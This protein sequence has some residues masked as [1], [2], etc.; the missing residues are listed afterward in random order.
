MKEIMI[1]LKPKFQK[2]IFQR[3]V[4]KYGGSVKASEFVDIPATSIRGYKNIYF[5]SV[6]KIL[7]NQLIKLKLVRNSEIERNSLFS[8]NKLDL[9]KKNLDKGREKRKQNLIILKKNIP[10][11]KELINE[12]QI[13]VTKWFKEYL[14]LL[15][16]G[17][18]KASFE[19]IGEDIKINYSNFNKKIYK[20]FEVKIPQK[21]LIDKDFV[22]FFGL[23]C[24]DRAGGKRFG[25]C[26][27]NKE[28]LNYTEIFLKKY[29]QKIEKILYISKGLKEP[30]LEY[31]KRFIINKETKG[32]C[33]SVHSPNGILASFFRYLLENLEE[34]LKSLKDKEVFFAGLFDAEG[35]VSLYNGSF[36]WACKNLPQVKIY[37]KILKELGFK[38][39]YDGAC[40]VSY[41]KKFF[42]N[43]I[44]PYIKHGNKINKTLLL[45]GEGGILL[46]EHRIVLNYINK[47]PE[48]TAKQITKA[49]K[50]KKVYSELRI[51][52]D[53]SL[54]SGKGYPRRFGIIPEGLKSTGEQNYNTH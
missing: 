20:K 53:L 54:I 51:L 17:F 14:G 2:E 30:N 28:I 31:D 22:Y 18:R 35:N 37:S 39:K 36:R 41:D 46:E 13:N 40:I 27:Q 29:N 47:F 45:C 1:K 34:F 48:S 8:F 4:N 49:L 10:K 12:N 26:N 32:W 7:L 21:F 44:F 16:S 11:I 52:K 25:I 24:G 5:N 9:I 33:L 3:L 19:L 43:Q 23:W 42:Y 15:N 38:N 6:P 50:K